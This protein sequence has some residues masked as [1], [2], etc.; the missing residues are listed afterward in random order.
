MFCVIE[1]VS[2]LSAHTF[3]TKRELQCTVSCET[4][5]MSLMFLSSE[6]LMDLF[7]S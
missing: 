1:H 2:P 7:G 6:C 4:T 5:N 3:T